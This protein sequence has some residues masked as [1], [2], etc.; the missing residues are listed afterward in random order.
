MNVSKRL[1]QILF[2]NPATRFLRRR[3]FNVGMKGYFDDL[4][5]YAQWGGLWEIGHAQ[6]EI[7][8]LE[9]D[10]EIRGKVL[11]LACGTGENALYLAQ[12]GYSVCGIDSAPHAIEKANTKARERGIE[13]VFMVADAFKL[14]RLGRTFDTVIESGLF[15]HLSDSQRPAYARSLSV[16]LRPR[17]TYYMLGISDREPPDRSLL[18]LAPRRLSREEIQATFTEGW[19]INWIREAKFETR[20]NEKQVMRAW[21]AS[22]TRL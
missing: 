16:V 9:H 14:E 20:F 17:G 8:E 19:R 11:D 3:F 5:A 22:V 6:Q 13:V 10:G 21:L 2:L 12:L 1:G 4:Y 15:H 7:M 18:A